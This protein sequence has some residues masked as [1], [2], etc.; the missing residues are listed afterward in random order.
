MCWSD[1]PA[2]VTLPQW[3]KDA[4]LHHPLKGTQLELKAGP[5][6]LSV[7]VDTTLQILVA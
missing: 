6:G 1:K 2:S 3:R 5:Q 4:V 7:P